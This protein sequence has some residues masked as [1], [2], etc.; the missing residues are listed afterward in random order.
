[1]K[2]SEVVNQIADIAQ[3]LPDRVLATGV[4]GT[5]ASIAV[6]ITDIF[7]AANAIVAFLAGLATLFYMLLK[8]HYFI[9][10]NETRKPNDPE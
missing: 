9:R 10:N 5:G 7:G 8:I 6:G 2:T 1:M 4:V 3:H